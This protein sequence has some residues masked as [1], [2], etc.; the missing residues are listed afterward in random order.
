LEEE[1]RALAVDGDVPDLVDD[2]EPGDV[3]ELELLLPPVLV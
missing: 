2:Q 3:E 1:V